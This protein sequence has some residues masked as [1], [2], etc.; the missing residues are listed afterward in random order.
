MSPTTL[1]T[2]RRQPGLTGRHVLAALLG[3]F[4]IVFAVNAWLVVEALSTHSGE[5]ANEPYRKGLAYN[6]R[7]AADDRQAALGWKEQLVLAQGRITV[8][9]SAADGEPVRGLSLHGTIGRP[10][11]ARHDAAIMLAETEPGRYTATLPAISAGE[12]L[13]AIEAR[14][15]QQ[16]AVPAPVFRLRRKLWLKP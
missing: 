5:V 16:G 12:W 8:A 14:E 13:V 10:S 1:P 4:G 6:T 11:T 9:L 15:V 7:I 3:F 2:I